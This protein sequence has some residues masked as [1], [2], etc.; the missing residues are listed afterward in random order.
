M[1]SAHRLVRDLTGVLRTHYPNFA[2]GLPLRRDEIPVFVYHDVTIEGLAEDLEFLRRNAYATLGLE[3]F[4]LRSAGAEPSNGKAVLLTFDDARP[5]FYHS[6]LPVLSAMRARAVLFAPTYWMDV[7]PGENPFMS[8]QQL[9]ECADS[10]WVDVQSHAHRHALV[11]TSSRLA[12]FAHPRSL[13]RYHVCDWPMRRIEGRD[14]LG[15]PPCGTPIYRAAPLL[16]ALTRY[17]ES[18]ELRQHCCEFVDAHGGMGFFGRKNWAAELRTVHAHAARRM[19]G[20]IQGA[21]DFRALVASEFEQT[22]AAF[23][24]HLG[25]APS[26]LAYPWVLGSQSSLELARHSGIRAA[27]GVALDYGRA[28]DPRLPVRIFGRLKAEWLH[29][30]PGQGRSSILRIGAR[31]LAGLGK[32][33]H[34]A[35]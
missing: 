21:D 32:T 1:D 3:E 10:G 17:L 5:S 8:W 28:R 29:A 26:S 11:F 7:P 19:P 31:K 15:R 9:R 22:R 4:L 33:P 25:Y 23:E 34:L 20:R 16:S 35:R 2:L 24:R 14:Q 30:L 27:F 18:E 6:A 12:G 13:A